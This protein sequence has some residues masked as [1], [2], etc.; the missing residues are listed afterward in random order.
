MFSKLFFGRNE[1]EKAGLNPADAAGVKAADGKCA[2]MNAGERGMLEA[3]D[4]VQ[5]VIRFTPQGEIL[6]ANENFLQTTGYRIEEIK[7]RHHR[8]F[9]DPEYGQSFEYSM[10]WEKLRRG[11]NE[12]AE[13]RRLAK[14][15]REIWLQASYNPV[16]DVAGRLV[17]VVK[18]A[19]DITEEK[20]H[21]ADSRGKIDAIERVMAV[22][23]FDLE[24]RILTANEGFLSLMGYRLDEVRGQHHKMFVEAQY[25]M[26][27]EYAEFWR[28]LKAGQADA[29]VYKR[30]AR[31]GRE[32][33]IQASYNPVRDASGRPFKVVKFA[34]DLTELI[35]QTEKT[36]S[37]A[38]HVA[39]STRELSSSIGEISRNM[40]LTKETAEQIQ[41][42]SQVSGKEAERLNESVAA[43]ESMVAMIREI[44]ARVN[45]L[46]LNAAI[47]AARAGEA[48]RGFAVVASEVKNLSDQTAKATQQIANEIGSVQTISGGV[49]QAIERTLAGVSRVNQYVAGVATAMEEQTI[50]TEEITHHSTDLADAVEVI[51]EHTRQ[52]KAA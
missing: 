25:A 6:D 37:T 14:G 36:Q 20:L 46:A 33:W 23:E 47:E 12:S 30:M 40:T 9:V 13:Y 27:A 17:E 35:T 31:G 3:L 19:T 51:L 16:Y 8:M 26:S 50:V 28:N 39:V 7:G 45:I 43:M 41:S 18:F 48:G 32:V 24:G 4:R 34:S 21:N 29:R 1:S 10:F 38:R 2:E 44:A 22:I 52:A 5:A 42:D 11:E 15:G 49:T